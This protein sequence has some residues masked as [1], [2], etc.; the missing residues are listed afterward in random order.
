MNLAFEVLK[1]MNPLLMK[2]NI[3][4]KETGYD[5]RNKNPLIIPKIKTTNF[6]IKSHVVSKGQKSGIRDLIR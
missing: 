4:P 5:L 1:N 6:G 3:L 2:D